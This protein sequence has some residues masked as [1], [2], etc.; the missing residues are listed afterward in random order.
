MSYQKLLYTLRCCP[1]TDH[2]LLVKYDSLLRDGLGSILNINMSESQWI[3]AS[4]PIKLGGLGIRR[5][6]SLALPAFLAS[7]A[8]TRSIQSAMLGA[9]FMD[10]DELVEKLTRRWME[11]S[12]CSPPEDDAPRM[13]SLWDGPLVRKEA[14]SLRSSCGDAYHQA[15][16]GAAASAHSGDWLLALPITSCGLRLDDE[17]IRIAV[18][19]RL[20]ATVCEPHNCPCGAMVTAD[21]SHGLSCRLGPGRLARHATLNDLISRGLSRAGI[22]NIK[23]P[24]GMSRTDGKRPDGLTL[25]PWRSGRCLV[26]DVT[27]SD[28]VAPSYLQSSSAFAG[29]AAE[30]AATRKITK[31]SQL[32]QTHQF[33]PIAFETMGPIN[34]TGLD[35]IKELGRRITLTTGDLKETSYLLQRLS[36]TIQRFNAIAFRGSFVQPDLAEA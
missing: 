35:F 8:G 18:C 6:A 19:L 32:L 12:Q 11:E 26:W 4:L 33:V 34:T 7:A 17:T 15:R 13:Q 28:T 30:Q 9:D 20:G 10:I 16:L 36:V 25:I 21:G 22:P 23:E 24:P 5:A 1:C 27:V 3:Q 14:M 29:A 31:Y 2:S